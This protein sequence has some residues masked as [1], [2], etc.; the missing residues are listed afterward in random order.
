[1][2]VLVTCYGCGALVKDIP[3]KPH[4]YLGTVA[5][6]W[7]V[8]G[9][10][11]A[12]QFGD[13]GYPQPTHRL[14]V[15]AYAVQHPGEPWRQSIQSVNVHLVSLYLVLE[16]GFTAQK[17]THVINRVLRRADR[18][19]WL[20]PPEPNGS[21]TILDVVKAQDIDQHQER[22]DQWSQDVWEGWTRHHVHVRDLATKTLNL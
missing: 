13:Y 10:V 15:D 18:F 19:E 6:C 11:L 12:K 22:V 2:E 9:Q 8:F 21:V 4:K 20:E 16:L 7:E 3:G 17:A 5:G 1:M 14:T